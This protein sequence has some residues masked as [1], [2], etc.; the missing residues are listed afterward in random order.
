MGKYESM[1]NEELEEELRMNLA[2]IE[3]IQ[4][5]NTAI[6]N[7]LFYRKHPEVKRPYSD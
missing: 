5:S 4:T 2:E 3:A 7:E 1:T 6:E